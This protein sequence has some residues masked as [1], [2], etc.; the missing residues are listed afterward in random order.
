VECFSAWWLALAAG[1][2]AVLQVRLALSKSGWPRVLLIV[3]G[4][5]LF[6]SMVLAGLYGSRTIVSSGLPNEQEIEWMRALH[7]SANALGFA[8]CGLLGWRLVGK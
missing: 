5:C 6:G 3:S 1:V 4:V 8:L 7:G 2:V